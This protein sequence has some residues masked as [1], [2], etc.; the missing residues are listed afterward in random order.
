LAT[1]KVTAMELRH[2]DEVMLY[3]Y[4]DRGA[5]ARIVTLKNTGNDITVF[6]KIPSSKMPF[7][8]DE[9]EQNESRA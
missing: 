2:G 9:E 7:R 5:C 8:P 4:N 6:E 3:L 1:A